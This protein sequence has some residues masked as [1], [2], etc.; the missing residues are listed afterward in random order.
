MN[1]H[2]VLLCIY[3]NVNVTLPSNARYNR[4]L[5]IHV[6]ICPRGK[7]PFKSPGNSQS[8]FAIVPQT[9]YIVPQSSAFNLIEGSSNET[10]KVATINKMYC[11]YVCKHDSMHMFIQFTYKNMLVVQ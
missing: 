2:N 8:I 1:T 7:S 9:T 10:N 11:M 4:S 6:T 3:R 5:Y